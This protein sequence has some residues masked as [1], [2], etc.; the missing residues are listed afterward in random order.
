MVCDAQPL[1]QDTGYP[2]NDTAK[3]FSSEVEI[4]QTTAYPMVKVVSFAQ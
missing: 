3:L 2:K 4:I 1:V